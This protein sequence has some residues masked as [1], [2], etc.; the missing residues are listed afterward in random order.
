MSEETMVPTQRAGL[1]EVERVIDTFTE[2][3]KTFTDI[4]RSTSWWLPFVLF[5]VL[6]L[7]SSFTIDMRVG[8][9]TVAQNT[10]DTNPKQQEKMADLDAA[11]KATQLR[12]MAASYRYS[13]YAA[14]LFVLAVA[15]L[16]AL[17]L[18]G[19][20]NFILGAKTTFRQM[21]AVWMYATLPRLLSAVLMIIL[22]FIGDNEGFQFRNP[23]GTNLGFYFPDAAPWLRTLMT[24]FDVVGLWVLALLVLGTS[25]VAGVKRSQAAMVVVGWWALFLVISIVAASFS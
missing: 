8:F 19:S 5:A 4:L 21:F 22:L 24:A 6:S 23:V 14:P 15:A 3:T 17:G 13:S 11:Q 20:F 1:S 9:D 18:W 7:L 16:G 25:I 2:P 10:M 12:L